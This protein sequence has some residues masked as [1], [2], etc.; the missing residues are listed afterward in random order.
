MY[1][2][3][4]NGDKIEKY[5]V[6]FDKDEISKLKGIIIEN[7]SYIAHH[8]ERSDYSPRFD[9]RN[10]I[11]HLTSTLV[12][13]KE[14]FE[15]TRDVY[16][17][18]YDE[19]KPPYLVKLISRL[20]NDDSKAIDE[21]LNYN[22]SGN[23]SIDDKI[24]VTTQEF[25]EI[26][27][28]DIKKKKNKLDELESLLEAKKLNKNQQD[29]KPYYEQLINLIKFNLVDSLSIIELSR[30]E[31]FLETKLPLSLINSQDN[32][33]SKALKREK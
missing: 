32:D 4:Q 30:V 2:F 17:Y 12:G 9:D 28:E 13:E 33:L 1:Y 19:Y 26:D 10:L 31:S 23:F 22:I 6:S 7:C 27:I 24:K 29:I 5:D 25:A 15:E 20:L 8:E 14:Y 3:K 21:I 16:L 18:S 11:K